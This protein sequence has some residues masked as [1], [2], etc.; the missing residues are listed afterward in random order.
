MVTIL[1][2]FENKNL[3]LFLCIQLFHLLALR[4]LSSAP[5]RTDFWNL[6][7]QR[8]G[9]RRLSIVNM[10]AMTG[11]SRRLFRSIRFLPA[12]QG[13]Q[14]PVSIRFA[15]QKLD[16]PLMHFCCL[17]NGMDYLYALVEAGF[18]TDLQRVYGFLRECIQSPAERTLT[19][20]VLC[21]PLAATQSVLWLVCLFT[22]SGIGSLPRLIY[23]SDSL[24]KFGS[25]Q[26]LLIL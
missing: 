16:G 7:Y 14:A 4:Q 5:A 20:R 25:V 11:L 3:P 2:P 8:W 17:H 9:Y 6:F 19:R 23:R 21:C 13:W 26:I 12:S 24:Y 22:T 10:A 15:S 1:T 18:T